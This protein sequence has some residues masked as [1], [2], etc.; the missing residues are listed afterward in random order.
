[1]GIFIYNIHINYLHKRILSIAITGFI[2]QRFNRPVAMVRNL[3]CYR[4]SFTYTLTASFKSSF[5]R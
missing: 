1:M 3:Y 2:K 5:S 4:Y